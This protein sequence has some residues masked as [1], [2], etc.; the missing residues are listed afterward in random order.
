MMTRTSS[1]SCFE[2][3]WRCLIRE[4]SN[5]IHSC[6]SPY[7]FNS[8][9]KNGSREKRLY[10]CPQK[11]DHHC[12]HCCYQVKVSWSIRDS[13]AFEKTFPSSWSRFGYSCF[14][15]S[16]LAV[17]NC[18][19]RDQRWESQ[20]NPRSR[21]SLNTTSH[22]RDNTISFPKER[23]AEVWRKRN[24]LLRIPDTH[25]LL[26]PNSILDSLPSKVH[27]L[28]LMQHEELVF[29][30]GESKRRE[31][32]HTEFTRLCCIESDH[33]LTHEESME[34]GA[35]KRWWTEPQEDRDCHDVC[36]CSWQER[37]ECLVR[38]RVKSSC[39]LR[40]NQ[41]KE[42]PKITESSERKFSLTA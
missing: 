14:L 42:N 2:R 18:S 4:E 38:E 21:T 20:G 27:H 29:S 39:C 26:E 31:I 40:V 16:F 3:V 11:R 30:L 6:L 19:V 15:A 41:G 25:S 8:F 7:Q 35:D 10:A 24:I 12:Q 36:S 34:S 23:K 22:G 32:C 13:I 28:I 5:D 37:E 9:S 1:S 17:Q 33:G